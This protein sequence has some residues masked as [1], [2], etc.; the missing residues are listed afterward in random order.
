MS[1]AQAM[2]RLERP[3]LLIDGRWG[4]FT[5]TAYAQASNLTRMKVDTVVRA[6]TGGTVE[7]LTAFRKAQEVAIATG[8]REGKQNWGAIFRADVIPAIKRAAMQAGFADPSLV[9]AQLS[10]ESANGTRVAAPYNWAGIKAAR[11]EP[12]GG[13]VSTTEV[14]NGVSQRVSARFR[15]FASVDDFVRF[16]LALLVRKWPGTRQATTAQQYADGLKVGRQGGYATE[17]IGV[18]T[19]ALAG[20][21]KKYA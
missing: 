14:I 18:Y 3:D 20:H 4:T 7:Q 10:H 11:G 1:A 13:S 5:K 12:T 6:L 21:Q 2:L 19:A 16:Y 17:K 8:A 15:A 9:I